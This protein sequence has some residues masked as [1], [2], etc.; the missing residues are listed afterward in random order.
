MCTYV[1]I[2]YAYI[3]YILYVDSCILQRTF[4]CIRVLLYILIYITYITKLSNIRI[5][6]Y[7]VRWLMHCTTD[8]RMYSS[9]VVHTYIHTYIYIYIN[10]YTYIHTYIHVYIY[11]YIHTYTHIYIT[12]VYIFYAVCSL[13][14]LLYKVIDIYILC[15]TLTHESI[16]WYLH[17]YECRRPID[18]LYDSFLTLFLNFFSSLFT[19]MPE[20]EQK[21]I[22]EKRN[23]AGDESA[24][25]QIFRC[26]TI[27]TFKMLLTVFF[28]YIHFCYCYTD[29]RL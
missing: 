21:R 1:Y 18:Y 11:I 25:I 8:I 14:T 24:E 9:V 28:T 23:R 13:S 29:V 10:I 17:M 26:A 19:P 16:L 5:Y 22:V 3:L 27:Q 15:C 12:C 7:A 6:V 20:N 2:Y 4:A